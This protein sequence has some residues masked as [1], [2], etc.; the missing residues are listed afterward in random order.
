MSAQVFAAAKVTLKFND[1]KV[2]QGSVVDAVLRLNSETT[3]KIQYNQLKGQTL[4]EAFYIYQAKPLMTKGSWDTLESEAKVIVV[5]IP[6]NRPLI[7]KLGEDSIEID[8]ESVEFLPTETP[9]GFL[10]ADFDIPD[11]ARIFNWLAII[12]GI[13]LVA[14]LGYFIYRKVRARNER[15]KLL[16]AIKSSLQEANDYD[17]I[18]QVWRKK[19]M[20]IKEFPHLDEHFKK[21]E[22]T[23][24]KYQFKPTQTESEKK[25]VISAYKEFLSSS[26]GGF[27]GI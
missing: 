22:L 9:E 21:L 2:K 25:E 13:S 26:E 1:Q 15:R 6:E 17:S 8:W 23:L 24:F 27:S 18:V 19:S 11:R 12:L 3:Q 14:S 5:K 16:L 7:H 4:G 10:F 20:Y